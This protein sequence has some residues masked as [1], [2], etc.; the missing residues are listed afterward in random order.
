MLKMKCCNQER[1][2]RFCPECG[3]KLEH[4]LCALNR[5]LDGIVKIDEAKIQTVKK[6]V[7]LTDNPV[8]HKRHIAR[9]EKTLAKWTSWRNAVR[10]A[11]GEA[12][13]SIDI[14]EPKEPVTD[15]GS[16]KKPKLD[17]FSAED[18]AKS[19]RGAI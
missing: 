9:V 12:G 6:D 18:V 5:H 7:K 4:P 10:V 2:S 15:K 16:H 8:L 14:P 11:I 19:K 1:T 3:K 17:A 13:G